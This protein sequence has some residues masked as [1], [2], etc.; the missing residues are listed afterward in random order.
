VTSQIDLPPHGIAHEVGHTLHPV[1]IDLAV[2]R[3]R[4]RVPLRSWQRA[5]GAIV[6]PS[7]LADDE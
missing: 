4:G 7:R 2:E 1:M 3:L 6:P 5:L